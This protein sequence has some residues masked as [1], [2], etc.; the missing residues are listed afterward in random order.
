MRIITCLVYNIEGD[1]LG[2]DFINNM[3]YIMRN[4]VHTSDL[5]KLNPGLDGLLCAEFIVPVVTAA[6]VPEH[7]PYVTRNGGEVFDYLNMIKRFAH[8]ERLL[9]MAREYKIPHIPSLKGMRTSQAEWTAL[10]DKVIAL[11]AAA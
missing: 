9:Q 6:T 2:D 3:K 5:R 1:V 10:I 7:K 8:K 4:V 11:H